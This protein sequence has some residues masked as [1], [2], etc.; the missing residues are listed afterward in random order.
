LL[1]FIFGKQADYVRSL[2]PLYVICLTGFLFSLSV[3]W[4]MGDNVSASIMEEVLEALPDTENIGLGG[5]LFVILFNNV[6]KS[7]LFMVLGVVA[8]IP[9]LYF[10]FMNGFLLGH[11]SYTFSADY[12]LALTLASLLP[13]GIIE[14]PT[15]LLSSTIGM[16]L[17]YRVINRLRGERGLGAEFGMALRLFATR[18]VPLLLLASIIEVTIIPILTFLFSL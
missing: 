17:G 1:G 9:P 15:I 14:V 13:H 6:T 8:C 11:F 18:I 2:A 4:Y 10:S 16:R 12:G 7:F 5:L 3:G